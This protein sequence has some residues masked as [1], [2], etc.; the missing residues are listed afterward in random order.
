[1]DT[2]VK[3]VPCQGHGFV[4]VRRCLTCLGSGK[5]RTDQICSCGR[6]AI[7]DV[8]TVMVCSS[9]YCENKIL[10]KTV[11]NSKDPT[12]MSREELELETEDF[13]SRFNFG[14]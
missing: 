5:V 9:D 14:F 1:M 2:T 8:A 13:W 12:S 3:C 4:G 6:P 11:Q 7:R 10:S